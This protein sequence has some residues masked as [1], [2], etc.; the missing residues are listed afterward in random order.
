MGTEA[1][2]ANWNGFDGAGLKSFIPATSSAAKERQ[3]TIVDGWVT[4]ISVK[5]LENDC[6]TGKEYRPTVGDFEKDGKTVWFKLGKQMYH[7]TFVTSRYYASGTGGLGGSTYA[8]QSKDA[9][10][11][12]G[13]SASTK[14]KYTA[15]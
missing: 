3:D 8:G 11:K 10:N 6:K 12:I 14:S 2:A 7:Q 15:A 1:R 13:T 4:T 5:S 9:P